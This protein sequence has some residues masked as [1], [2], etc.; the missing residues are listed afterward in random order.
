[1]DDFE[2]FRIQ[3]KI[4]KSKLKYDQPDKALLWYYEQRAYP[5][6]S[7]PENWRNEAL[8]HIS[9]NNISSINS[10]NALSWTQLGPGNIG[11]RIRAIAVHPLSLIHI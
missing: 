7:I 10:P 1:M 11:G 8:R 5:N 9:A 4:A 3:K 6:N 2:N